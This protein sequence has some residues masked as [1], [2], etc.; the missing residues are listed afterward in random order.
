V[1]PSGSCAGTL[2]RHY[3]EILK[4]DPAFAPRAKALADKTYE[5]MQFLVDVRGM[6]GLGARVNGSICYHDS[7]SS[8]R[9]MGVQAQPRT[10]LQ[11]AGAQICELKENQVCCGFGGLFAVKYPDISER[12][13]DDKIA[14]ATGT[15]AQTLTGGDLGCLLHLAG[16]M[17][18]RGI[19]MDVRHVAEILAG[20]TSPPL[21]KPQ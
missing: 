19:A 6:T 1:A 11:S 12:M 17:K 14:D 13:A 9:E 15:G 7:C 16:R 10:L 21:G 8:L 2:K 5:L 4:D 3:P 18:R 20:E